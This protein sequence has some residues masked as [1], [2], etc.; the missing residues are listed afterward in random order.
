MKNPNCDGE[1]CTSETGEVRFLPYAGGGKKVSHQEFLNFIFSQPREREINMGQNM[2]YPD[3]CGCMMV[4]YGRANGLEGLIV[5]GFRDIGES[6]E[7]IGTFSLEKSIKN[8]FPTNDWGR[9]TY[10]EIQD[11]CSKKLNK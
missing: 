8:Y 1:H 10:G 5:C 2:A 9:Y 3:D 4:H 6:G 11:F 7:E